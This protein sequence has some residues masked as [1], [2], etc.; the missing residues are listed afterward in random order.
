VQYRLPCNGGLMRICRHY[1][2]WRFSKR[3]KRFHSI[4][5]L[6]IE[7]HNSVF[8]T[9][10]IQ[11][12]CVSESQQ[13]SNYNK[14]WKAQQSTIRYNPNCQCDCERGTAIK[15]DM[16]IHDCDQF[17]SHLYTVDTITCVG[18]SLLSL[19]CW[20]FHKSPS[21]HNVHNKMLL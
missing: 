21:V 2:M 12:A 10:I 7:L 14:I 18:F 1:A 11:N 20:T 16:S 17:V 6:W 5:A 19:H 9:H 4:N 8:I 13:W 15:L 3:S